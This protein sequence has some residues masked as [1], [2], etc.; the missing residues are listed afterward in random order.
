[1]DPK[2]SKIEFRYNPNQTD[3]EDMSQEC[4][5]YLKTKLF[6]A[7][8]IYQQQ[9]E[10]EMLKQNVIFHSGKH[11]QMHEMLKNIT[12]QIELIK[13]VI[14]KTRQEEEIRMV[15]NNSLDDSNEFNEFVVSNEIATSFVIED[16]DNFGKNVLM[17]DNKIRRNFEQNTN[18]NYI[19]TEHHDKLNNNDKNHEENI[20]SPLSYEN[21]KQPSQLTQVR[22][23]NI[24][25]KKQMEKMKIQLLEQTLELNKLKSDKFILFNELNE[26]IQSLRRVDLDLLNNYVK[27]NSKVKTFNKFEMPS[28]KGLK[29]N[30]LSAQCQLGK[31]IKSDLITKKLDQI[32]ED[33]KIIGAEEK[34][35]NKLENKDSN[36][37][38]MEMYLNLLKKT[39]EEFDALLDRKLAKKSKTQ[40]LT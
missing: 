31:I 13:P 39:E 29:Y 37:L 14:N 19:I 32:D 27:N 33:C 23:E 21:N 35:K 8:R 36:L 15:N 28:A 4:T 2:K 34:A 11:I 17:C 38:Q 30:V 26:I 25:L 3:F 9:E 24:E 20:P 40:N 1:M 10:I 7:N 22:N 18:Q 12:E 16:M 5:A 6:M